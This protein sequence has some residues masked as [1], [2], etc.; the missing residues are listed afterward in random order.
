MPAKSH[1]NLKA[2]RFEGELL[3]NWAQLLDLAGELCGA[4][5]GTR[6]WFSRFTNGSGTDD[7]RT[8][9]EHCRVLGS[10]IRE[11]KDTIMAELRR[12]PEDSQPSQ[13]I[14]AWLYALDTM[15][16]EASTRKTCSWTVE[17]SDNSQEGEAG[18][19]DITLRR[20]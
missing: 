16:Q 11:R 14:A 4:S 10:G 7:G 19:G 8:V 5:D 18:G 15:M 9:M 3:P 1:E 6:R 13:I 17:G 20:V 2:I 12:V